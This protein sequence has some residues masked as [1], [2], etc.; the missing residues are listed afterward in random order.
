MTRESGPKREASRGRTAKADEKKAGRSRNLLWMSAGLVVLPAGRQS[1]YC[2]GF[3]AAAGAEAAD[4]FEW[5]LWC[6]DFVVFFAAAGAAADSAAG[7][8][9]WAK[10]PVANRPTTRA[11]SSFFMLFTSKVDCILKR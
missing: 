5:L 2:A 9:A 4:F 11:A 8:E 3:S 6:V 10:A 1:H 7:A